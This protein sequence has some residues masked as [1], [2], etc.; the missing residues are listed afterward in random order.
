MPAV[1]RWPFTY[2]AHNGHLLSSRSSRNVDV[3]L[4]FEDLV[5]GSSDP[6]VGTTLWL[7]S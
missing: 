6:S 5:G 7:V 1:A 2:C 4:V 3:S